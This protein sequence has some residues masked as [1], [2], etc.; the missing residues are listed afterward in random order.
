MP[1]LSTTNKIIFNCLLS[2]SPPYVE[3]I[4]GNRQCG[5]RSNRSATD[6]IVCIRQILKKNWN[7]MMQFI[8]I[9]KD[10]DSVRR[11]VLYNILFG[12]VIPVKI[13]RL[14]KCV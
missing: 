12:H 8:N 2:K 4:I 11:K 13:L 10:Y 7:K 9:K 1:L 6:R 3:E 14:I 5:Y